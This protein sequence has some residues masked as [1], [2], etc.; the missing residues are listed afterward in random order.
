MY[1]IQKM[2]GH[3]ENFK[4]SLEAVMYIDSYEKKATYSCD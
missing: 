4:P 1:K 2:T 3:T